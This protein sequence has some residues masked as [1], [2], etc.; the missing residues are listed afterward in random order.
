MKI[1]IRPNGNEKTPCLDCG[2]TPSAI[3][4]FTNGAE[5][6][7]KTNPAFCRKCFKR[8]YNLIDFVL[9]NNTHYDG[10]YT[11]DEVC[12][13][14]SADDTDEYNVCGNYKETSTD[15][16]TYEYGGYVNN[17]ETSLNS[18]TDSISM[19]P[20]YEN[21]EDYEAEDTDSTG[22]DYTDDFDEYS[23]QYC[24]R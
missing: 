3:Y 15:D 24:W 5:R 18:S 8:L 19:S 12:E 21:Q 17:G 11:D 2:K 6:F 22:S 4:E 9:S 7:Y 23:Y 10:Y 14:A 16:S 20:K 13:E 1:S